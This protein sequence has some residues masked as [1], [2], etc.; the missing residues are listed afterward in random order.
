MAIPSRFSHITFLGTASACPR[1]GKRNV[2][3]LTMTCDDGVSFLFDCGEGTQ[4]QIGR[5]SSVKPSSISHIFVTHLHGDHF[6]GIFGLLCSMAMQNRT[7]DV[8]ITGPKGIEHIVHTVMDGSGGWHGFPMN[9]RELSGEESIDLGLTENGF[10]VTAH[11]LN[12]CIPTYGYVVQEPIKPGKLDGKKA[13]S[14][15]AKTKQLGILKSGK[16][17][18]LENGTIIHAADCVG[19]TTPGRKVVLLQDT[20]DSSTALQA[21]QDCDLLIHECTYHDAMRPKAI[22]FGHSTATMAGEFARRVG[23]KMLTLTHFSARYDFSPKQNVTNSYTENQSCSSGGDVNMETCPNDSKQSSSDSPDDSKVYIEDL[24]REASSV[25]P[26]AE[27]VAAQDFSVIRFRKGI[28][29]DPELSIKPQNKYDHWS[30]TGTEPPCKRKATE[31]NVN[32]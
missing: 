10:H 22:E 1:P 18:T 7:K 26:N 16:D 30:G 21:S 32:I 12:H 6:F 11:F 19:A 20:C 23:A 5:C 4:H 15:G 25:C 13:M 27:V 3:A 8:T 29:M 2:S 31:D 24:I 9:F 28:R 17:V 14:L